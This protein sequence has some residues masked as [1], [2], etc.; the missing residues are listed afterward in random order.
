MMPLHP[1]VLHDHIAEIDMRNLHVRC[2]MVV[3]GF[4]M[5]GC[6]GTQPT[7]SGYMGDVPE[8]FTTIPRNANYL[9]AANTATSR[10][11][12][13]AIDKATTGA[14]TEIGRQ[15][16]TRISGLQKGFE[17][18]V[19]VGSDAQLL[20]QF[21]STSKTVVST[22][23]SGSRVKYQKH[24]KDGSIWRA[25]VLVEYPVGAANEALMQAI[26]KNDQVYSRVRGTETFKE[27]DAE[28][29]KYE[30]FKRS[31]Q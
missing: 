20:Q 12:Q 27:L 31:Q 6:G 21:A 10:D 2:L 18:E 3:F 8:W 14:R 5:F 24:S 25:Y 19:G 11:L 26:K 16:D 30:A 15:L 9:F 4:A 13:L 23:F 29:E 1:I 22:S 17:E 7:Q 28:V